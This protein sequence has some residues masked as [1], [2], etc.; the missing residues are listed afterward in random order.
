MFVVGIETLSS[1]V[2]TVNEQFEIEP[3]RTKLKIDHFVFLNL[4]NW[5]LHA[6]DDIMLKPLGRN[7]RL[8]INYF[9]LPE[10][11]VDQ[12][13]N[14][15]NCQYFV[16]KVPLLEQII[17]NLFGDKLSLFIML[18]NP[19]WPLLLLHQRFKLRFQSCAF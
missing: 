3:H 2:E 9:S 16:L 7:Q 14:L 12:I 13:R 17:F 6:I 5:I 19:G 4:H 15:V 8:L 11:R 1:L 10:W 18:C